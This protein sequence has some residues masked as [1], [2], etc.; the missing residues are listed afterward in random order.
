M[1][2]DRKPDSDEGA[3]KLLIDSLSD[4]PCSLGDLRRTY[5]V[6]PTVAGRAVAA[7]PIVFASYDQN[8]KPF[9]RLLVDPVE[10]TL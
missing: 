2:T 7:F 5:S 1:K 9:V 8:G 10:A 3:F 6:E 4:G